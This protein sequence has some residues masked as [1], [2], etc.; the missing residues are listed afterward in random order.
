MPRPTDL[1]KD[2][3][4][5]TAFRDGCICHVLETSDPRRD[6]RRIRLKQR[7]QR[8]E[9]LGEGAFGIVWKETLVGG[10]GESEIQD[11]AVKRIQKKIRNS[12]DVDYTR[13][14]EAIAKFSRGRVG[15]R[16]VVPLWP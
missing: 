14:L 15:P 3:K 12:Y 6:R 4:L 7:W 9:T 5:K 11:R 16:L 13:E 1:V 2:S 10:E 8:G